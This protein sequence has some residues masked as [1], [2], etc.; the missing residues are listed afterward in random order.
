MPFHSLDEE[1]AMMS[2]SP[3]QTIA[4]LALLLS[5][6]V[7][8]AA[9]AEVSLDQALADNAPKVLK[10]LK[11]KGVKNVGVLKFLVREGAGKRLDNIGALNRTLADRL[12]AALI[13]ASPEGKDQD[14]E[15]GVL[16][17]TNETVA[18]TKMNSLTHLTPSGRAAFFKLRAGTF[19]RA[20]G[21]LEGG[22]DAFLTGEAKLSGDFKTIEITVQ[23]FLKS[24]PRDLLEVCKFS[25]ATDVRTVAETG[26]RYL[27]PLARGSLDN[28]EE[29]I[30][31]ANE[32]PT[33]TE[34]AK[35]IPT[36][37]DPKEKKEEKDEEEER[38]IKKDAPVKMQI[39][40][41][42]REIPIVNGRVATPR[43]GEKVKIRLTNRT[44]DDK[45]PLTYGV[46]LM[47]N[48]ENTIDPDKTATRPADCRKWILDPGE[49]IEID[50]FQFGTRKGKEFTVLSEEESDVERGRI[51]YGNPGMIE[52][53]VFRGVT[54]Q[55]APV[56]VKLK[57]PDPERPAYK[58]SRGS[59]RLEG[60]EVPGD[61]KLLKEALAKKGIP[62][63][64]KAK[65]EGMRGMIVKGEEKDST[66]K[67]VPFKYY[68]EPV[69]FD[70]IRYY[71]PQK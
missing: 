11:D 20:W 6:G 37:D 15:V 14:D 8:S 71:A 48:G 64:N 34:Y 25:A 39:F 35:N 45:Q 28:N 51:N 62:A 12:E 50:A 59:I 40:Y 42:N 43:E 16:L 36:P 33:Y 17:K 27:S 19:T 32:G 61:L 7:T 53:Y 22:P 29:K 23:A 57:K 1:M 31:K 2:R 46:V 4:T 3:S 13:L 56:V 10:F 67:V 44:G 49:T 9:A 70:P 66:V 54:E 55:E 24:S 60:N 41:N 5:V 68:D 30:V 63:L 18:A 69:Y 65:A 58:T 47:L 21:R 26:R 52:F 38:K